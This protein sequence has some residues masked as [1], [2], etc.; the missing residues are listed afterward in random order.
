MTAVY[1]KPNHDVPKCHHREVH[2]LLCL[3]GEGV[4]GIS[5]ADLVEIVQRRL[6]EKLEVESV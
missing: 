2:I 6:R 5:L 3:D 4:S 1:S